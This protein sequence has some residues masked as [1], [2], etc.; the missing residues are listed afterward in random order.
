VGRLRVSLSSG[1]TSGVVQVVVTI[2]TP[3]GD[4]KSQPVRVSVNSGFADQR[5]FTFSA[6]NYNFPGLDG[7]A[8]P[9]PSSGFRRNV[10]AHVSD[11]YSNPVLPGTA[12]YFNTQHGTVTTRDNPGIGNVSLTDIQG[13]AYQELLAGNPY[14]EG[15]DAHPTLGPGYSYVYAQTIG[16]NGTDIIDSVLVLWTGRPIITKTGGPATFAIPNGGS[17][18]PFTFTVLDRLGH[19][20]S[21]GT[22]IGIDAAAVSFG[23]D[24]PTTLFDTFSTGAGI[25]DFT[26]S[27]FDADPADAD[28][29]L[30]GVVLTV[31]I[32]HP[33]YGLAKLVLATGSVD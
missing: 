18:G 26:V 14:P 33:D 12:V 20:M 9:L 27:I 24:V 23:G 21:A 28:P 22:I 19:P 15:A 25:T 8:R 30:T 31:T 7:V 6:D 5:H 3:G 4:I 1:T 11:K 2:V 17:A 10:Y 32:T 29:P 16:Q 13:F